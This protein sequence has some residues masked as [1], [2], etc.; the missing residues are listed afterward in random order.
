MTVVAVICLPTARDEMRQRPDDAVAIGGGTWEVYT[1][2]LLVLL[3]VNRGSSDATAPP[4]SGCRSF[5][6]ALCV[7]AL[8]LLLRAC[9]HLVN[10]GHI[11]MS[12]RLVIVQVQI[13]TSHA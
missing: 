13:P 1:R 4:A 3:V 10:C 8:T 6:S 9:N 7:S 11:R 5:G 2:L 12:G